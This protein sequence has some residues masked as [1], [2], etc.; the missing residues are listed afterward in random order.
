M[1]HDF[2]IVTMQPYLAM[3]L[4]MSQVLVAA[5]LGSLLLP[6]TGIAAPQT[7]PMAAAAVSNGS[8]GLSSG[9]AAR[10]SFA[11][12]IPTNQGL[13][14]ETWIKFTTIG[15]ANS[16]FAAWNESN[17]QLLNR[18]IPKRCRPPKALPRSFRA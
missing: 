10:I 6:I 5:L 18:L 15:A 9:G 8:I 17:I 1:F 12:A 16:I 14:W 3:R 7:L 4:K 11:T 13:T 2:L